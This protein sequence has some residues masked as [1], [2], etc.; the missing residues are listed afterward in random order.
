M[1]DRN[2]LTPGQAATRL[3]RMSRYG[4]TPTPEEEQTARRDLA[5]A[6]LYKE[7]RDVLA[8][9]GGLDPVGCAH[10]VGFILGA[11]GVK[12]DAAMLIEGIVRQA[13]ADA[14]EA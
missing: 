13:V 3:A 7:A 1:Q 5:L 4:N 8:Q 14:Q 6:R 12:Y 10:V 2:I 9:S 11:S